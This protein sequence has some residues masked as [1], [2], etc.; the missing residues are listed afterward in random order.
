[1]KAMVEGIHFFKT[2]SEASSRSLDAFVRL[3]DAELIAETYRHYKDIFPTIPYPD[4]KGI[5]NVLDEIAKKDSKAKGLKPESFIDVRFLKELD[6]SGWSQR[7][8]P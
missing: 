5:Q 8:G 7:P 6:A 4:L 1:M 3:R 2:Q